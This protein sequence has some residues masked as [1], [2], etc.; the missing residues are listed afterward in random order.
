MTCLVM[1][2]AASSETARGRPS[3]LAQCWAAP[4]RAKIEWW[5][6]KKLAR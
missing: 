2:S 4:M 5:V 6:A 3:F 1:T